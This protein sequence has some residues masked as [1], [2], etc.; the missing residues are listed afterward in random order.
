M[1]DQKTALDLDELFG[2]ARAVKVK[3]QGQT[4]ELARMEA[5]SPSQVAKVQRLQRE[6][7]AMQVSQAAESEDGAQKLETLI[8]EI[9][10]ALCASLPL[11]TMNFALKMR[12]IDFYVQE[13]NGPKAM[14][15]DPQ[16]PTGEKSSP[17]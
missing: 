17:A 9:L 5:F 10:K 8:D 2:Q 13:T 11:E 1:S 7:A 3:W 6:A 4:Y 16:K 15:T 14:E 12:V